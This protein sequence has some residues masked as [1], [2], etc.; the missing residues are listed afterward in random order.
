MPMNK[1]KVQWPDFNH[2][3]SVF[4][5]RNQIIQ[6]PKTNCRTSYKQLATICFGLCYRADLVSIICFQPPN[7]TKV[8]ATRQVVSGRR[9]YRSL[10][11]ETAFKAQTIKSLLSHQKI[12]W[13]GSNGSRRAETLVKGTWGSDSRLATRGIINT[14]V[15]CRSDLRK[16]LA[17]S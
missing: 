8:V 10:Y 12:R 16:R 1:K 11:P 7:N 5:V 15:A 17:G 4:C 2:S 13:R 14:W 3:F 6:W 9:K